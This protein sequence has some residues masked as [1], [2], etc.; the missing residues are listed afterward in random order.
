MVHSQNQDQITM[1]SI[2]TTL[3]IAG[4]EIHVYSN[5][6]LNDIPSVFDLVFTMHGR[7]NT[8]LSMEKYAY[9]ILKAHGE[10]TK[11]KGRGLLV[12]SFDQRNHGHRLVDKIRNEGWDK[13]KTHA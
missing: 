9:S 12:V 5:G 1:S 4:I 10:S 6:Q 8:Y 3:C 7:G 2:K 13:N 11:L